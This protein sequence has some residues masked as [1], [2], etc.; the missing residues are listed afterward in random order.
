MT[1]NYFNKSL[2]IKPAVKPEIIS[3]TKNSVKVIP[4]PYEP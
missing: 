4:S 1:G 2:L 3:F